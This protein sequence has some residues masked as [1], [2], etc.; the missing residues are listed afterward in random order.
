MI[1]R[2]MQAV[3]TIVLSLR[4]CKGINSLQIDLDK[5]LGS[6]ARKSFALVW[7][8]SLVQIQPKATPLILYLIFSIIG[9]SIFTPN[10]DSYPKRSNY[11][12]SE[13]RSFFDSK[14]SSSSFVLEIF[15]SVLIVII[16]SILILN[17]PQSEGWSNISTGQ[18]KYS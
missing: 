16:L 18:F 12:G 6:L 4:C 1:K 5:C 8:R 10:H 7:Q 2:W 14:K 9:N 13:S 15:D 17:C 11:L 3:T